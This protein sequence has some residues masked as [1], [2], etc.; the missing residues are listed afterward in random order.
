MT[1]EKQEGKKPGGMRLYLGVFLLVLSLLIPLSS[2][3]IVS[4]SMPAALKTILVG[5][6]TL[7][8]PE[9][10]GICAIAL[11]GK[12]CFNAIVSVLK[13]GLK[14]LAPSGSVGKA[15]YYFGLLIFILTFIP[16]FLYSYFP[17]LIP[18]DS[19]NRIYVSAAADISFVISLFILGGDFW[20]KLRSLFV[21]EARA[22]FPPESSTKSGH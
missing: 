10:L 11:L 16:S 14:R 6:V 17:A 13:G 12:E 19:P 1:D 9:V 2:I 22:S 5:L 8:G 18:A 4:S 7:G 3:W 21:W 20:D 15:R